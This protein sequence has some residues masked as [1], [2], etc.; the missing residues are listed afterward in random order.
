MESCQNFKD[1]IVFLLEQRDRLSIIIDNTDDLLEKANLRQRWKLMGAN[2]AF[3]QKQL[4]TCLKQQL[5]DLVPISF[6]F[7]L[8]PDTNNHYLVTLNIQNQGRT[9]TIKGFRV[10]V[11]HDEEFQPFPTTFAVELPSNTVILPNQTISIVCLTDF[12]MIPFCRFTAMVDDNNIVNE[13][14]EQNNFLE[15]IFTPPLTCQSEVAAVNFAQNTIDT[16]NNTIEKLSIQLV[17]AS[18]AMKP[19]ILQKIAKLEAQLENSNVKLVNARKSLLVCRAHNLGGVV[20][21]R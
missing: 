15:T 10:I 6:G 16:I 11:G 1:E 3:K 19:I 13:I 12:I 14:D 20:T 21:N 18:P 7:H 9:A 2:I 17:N 5:P 4:E 8:I